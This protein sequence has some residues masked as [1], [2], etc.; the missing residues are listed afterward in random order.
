MPR[1]TIKAGAI[2]KI[3]RLLWTERPEQIISKLKLSDRHGV[4][5]AFLI[6]R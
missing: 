5:V 1:Q 2:T 6:T 3:E 4:S